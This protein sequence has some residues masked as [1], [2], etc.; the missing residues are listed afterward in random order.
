MMLMQVLNELEP[1][2]TA[3]KHEWGFMCVILNR[4]VLGIAHFEESVKYFNFA[5]FGADMQQCITV[6]TNALR[7]LDVQIFI[8]CQNFIDLV[9]LD[10]VAYFSVI[11][12]ELVVVEGL[13]KLVGVKQVIL[14]RHPVPV[15][16]FD[17][18]QMR[19]LF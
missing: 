4:Q 9:H 14:F 16:L 19:D 11:A 17:F 3:G 10:K 7:W 6:C 18:E 8:C 13:I 12:F 1:A 2:F 5:V 15:R